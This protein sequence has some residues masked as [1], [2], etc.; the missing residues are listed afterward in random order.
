M[1]N[2][3][4]RD[5]T[6]EFWVILLPFR[7]NQHGGIKI[8]EQVTYKL[9]SS[10]VDYIGTEGVVLNFRQARKYNFFNL[11]LVV[12]KLMFGYLKSWKICTWCCWKKINYCA[13]A[14]Y[15]FLHKNYLLNLA[16]WAIVLNYKQTGFNINSW[17][18]ADRLN[19]TISTSLKLI[20][21]TKHC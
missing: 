3:P 15:I 6:L 11:F 1:S 16:R 21:K 18:F 2:F 12:L 19:V 14:C 9:P 10:R 8:T 4:I 7:F 5:L 20:N 17:F 13:E